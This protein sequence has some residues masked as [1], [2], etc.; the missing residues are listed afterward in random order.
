[1]DLDSQ[2]HLQSRC[3]ASIVVPRAPSFSYDVYRHCI[4]VCVNCPIVIYNLQRLYMK[5]ANKRVK[6]LAST[7]KKKEKEKDGWIHLEVGGT[8][9]EIGFA[10]GTL[11]RRHFPQVLKVLPFNVAQELKIP[12][13]DYL[14]DC[15]KIFSPILDEEE[16]AFI[17]E[18]LRGIVAGASTPGITYDFLV[19]WNSYLSMCTYYEKNHGTEGLGRCCAFIATGTYTKTGEIVMAHNTHSDFATGF[20]LNVIMKVS[21]KDSAASKRSNAFVMQTAPGLICSSSDWFLCENG[22]IGCETTIANLNYVPEFNKAK[23]S[24]GPSDPLSSKVPYYLRIRKA[25]QYGKTLDN[26][27]EIMSKRSAGDYACTWFLGDVNTG[28]IMMLEDGGKSIGVERTMNGAFHGCN[29]AMTQEVSML[30]TARDDKYNPNSTT[31]ARNLR[32]EYLLF[33]KYRGELDTDKAKKILADHY[34]VSRSKYRIGKMNIC[35]HAE[36]EWQNK[37]TNK[38]IKNDTNKEIKNDTNKEIKNERRD[39][40]GTIGSLKGATDGKVVDSAMAKKMQFEGRMGSSCGR[41][42]RRLDYGLPHD[43]PIPNMPKHKWT[44]I[45]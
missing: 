14:R 6:R 31:G 3:H 33:D 32:M 10:H 25:M 41:A 38:E 42:F 16:W 19:A 4:H 30:S 20:I 11:L 37:D 21:P 27:V 36:L 40:K 23:G 9:Y 24:K 1:M 2:S 26:Y 39:L 28:E 45:I 13:A 12:Y 5:T 44:K 22:I 18:E 43:M 17:K 34:D 29:D 7:Q 15:K 35:K 8:P